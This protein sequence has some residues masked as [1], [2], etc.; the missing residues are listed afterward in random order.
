MPSHTPVKD[1]SDHTA[2]DGPS[3][4]NLL[5]FNMEVIAQAIALVEGLA[6]QGAETYAKPFGAHLRHVIEHH[7]AL[8]MPVE[9][10]VVDYDQ[11]PRDRRLERDPSHALSRLHALLHLLSAWPAAH[12]LGPLRVRGIGGV[13][14]DFSFSLPSS[15][16]RELAFVA[17]HAIH[18][19]ALLHAP[20]LQAGI[21]VGAAFGW[22]PAT[23]AHDRAQQHLVSKPVVTSA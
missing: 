12:G 18:H 7:E 20:A 14:G 10:G 4:E 5:R 9:A 15:P 21:A 11:R 17:S 3:V 19:F 13:A 6:Q 16:A 8:L 2:D 22:A 1:P 23:V